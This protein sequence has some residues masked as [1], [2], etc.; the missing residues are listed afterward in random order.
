MQPETVSQFLPTF[1]SGQAVTLSVYAYTADDALRP[2]VVLE[3]PMEIII[4]TVQ[5]ELQI[6]LPRASIRDL[7]RALRSVDGIERFCF[8][9]GT[10]SPVGAIVELD[11]TAPF[12]VSELVTLG[13]HGGYYIPA[14]TVHPSHFELWRLANSDSIE[15]IQWFASPS[16]FLDA[17][18]GGR[19]TFTRQLILVSGDPSLVIS[20]DDMDD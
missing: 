8:V 17:I 5:D 12:V 9:I 6:R 10:R 7:C 2:C 1:L 13:P 15:S 18:F 3:F 19:G 4:P 14:A 20:L 16:R 11:R